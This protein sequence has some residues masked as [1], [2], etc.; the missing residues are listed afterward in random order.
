ML[1]LNTMIVILDFSL[2]KLIIFQATPGMYQTHSFY[3]LLVLMLWGWYLSS[4]CQVS[5]AIS[6]K[7]MVNNVEERTW[8]CL[9]LWHGS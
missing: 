1:K 5:E 4:L 9:L 7:T 3:R 8:W 2:L 6:V